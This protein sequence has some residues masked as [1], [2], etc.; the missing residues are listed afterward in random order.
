MTLNLADLPLPSE[1]SSLPELR[2]Y[3]AALDSEIEDLR[4]NG[5]GRSGLTPSELASRPH[6]VHRLIEDAAG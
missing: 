1:E 5:P 3:Q 2:V 6:W 4:A